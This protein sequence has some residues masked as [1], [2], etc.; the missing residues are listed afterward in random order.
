MIK[1]LKDSKY[2]QKI[3]KKDVN[4]IL[5][6][7]LQFKGDIEFKTS[8]LINGEYIGNIKSTGL[9]LIGANAKIK[10]N[11]ETDVLISYGQIEGTV[12]A[13]TYIALCSG[14]VFKGDITTPEMIQEP[15]AIIK[16]QINM[17]SKLKS[18]KKVRGS[19]PE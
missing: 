6:E 14:S 5:S 7:D 17:P 1:K 19:I 15:K 9:L 10:S 3:G 11:I 4:T 13:N 2:Y 18:H 16:G 8:F 12:K